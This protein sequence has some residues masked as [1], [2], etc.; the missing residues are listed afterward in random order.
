[1][2][3]ISI[4]GHVDQLDYAL[5]QCV[6]LG[7]FHP[8]TPFINSGDRGLLKEKNPYEGLLQKI[9]EVSGRANVD[10]S[11]LENISWEDLR[12]GDIED[13]PEKIKRFQ[14]LKKEV[15]E[16][17]ERNENIKVSEEDVFR[18]EL[19]RFRIGRMPKGE[20][21]KLEILSNDICI[22]QE[23]SVEKQPYIF[24]AYLTTA[25][26]AEEVDNFYTSLGFDRILVPHD[27]LNEAS[28]VEDYRASMKN[29]DDLNL[30]SATEYVDKINE[31]LKFLIKKQNQLTDQMNENQQTLEQ[32]AY[33][34]NMD[35][36]FDEL[37]A[38][39]F[40]E[41][42]FGRLPKDSYPKLE[43]YSDRMFVFES[44]HVDERYYWG[45][46]FTPTTFKAEI[47]GLFDSLY[48]ERIRIPSFVHNTPQETTE[49]L[50]KA[51]QLE[52][53]KIK[54]VEEELSRIEHKVKLYLYWAYAR[55]KYMNESFN[56]RSYVTLYGNVFHMEGYVPEKEAEA[57]KNALNES[58]AHY[59]ASSEEDL[60]K[61]K[62]QEIEGEGVEEI[63]S[64]K[65]SPQSVDSD[66]VH[67]PPTLLENSW[68][69]KPFEMF[70][71]M[72]GTPAYNEFDPTSFI[73]ITYTI[74]FGVM[75]GDFGQ[76]LCLFLLGL[77][78]YKKKGQ[79]LGAVMTR[80]GLSGA[81]FGLIYGE[82][83][84]NENILTPLYK[85]FNIE[86]IPYRALEDT[87]TILI[88]SIVIGVL[89]ILISIFINIYIGIKQKNWERAFFSPNGVAGL[90]FYTT[91]LG[92]VGTIFIVGKNLVPTA[93][94]VLGLVLPFFL[95]YF[96]EVFTQL[97]SG[98]KVHL[99][100][101]VGEYILEGFF[102]MFEVVLSFLSNTVSF[103]RV[104]GFVLSHAGMMLVV[105]QITEMVNGGGI[106][107][108]IFG[109]IFVM[110]LEGLLVGI[111]CLRLEFYE[112]FSHFMGESGVPFTPIHIGGK[113]SSEE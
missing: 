38:S 112:M 6:K 79:Q 48:F 55:V 42:R 97:V 71:N 54:G 92:T 84:G 60:S 23:F 81:F 80:I 77:Y 16:L 102:E 86:G 109:N 107:V 111:Q 25:S 88:F 51:V 52:K 74:L 101:G 3:L 22:H 56:L 21:K 63:D 87:N 37:F 93:L 69:A 90:I 27:I 46:Y 82:V 34:K 14:N 91:A 11:G 31:Q 1:M 104:G 103:L 98:Q 89:L 53:E 110:A 30:E 67:M 9:M 76:G 62:E 94:I 17:L 4:D 96:K 113:P 10:L 64:L 19:L 44:F 12:L 58:S 35:S 40:I 8:E 2:K 72:Y 13:L 68:F 49:L 95:M 100:S 85:A 70:T 65:V 5:L 106:F 105:G 41:I 36:T 39:E 20:V 75:F 57:F 83:F 28:A 24:S 43:Y 99:E 7:N 18:S 32:I 15:V 73:S 78:L 108:I 50:E 47:D 59:L 29:V 33:I 45:V 66:L 26:Q 61:E